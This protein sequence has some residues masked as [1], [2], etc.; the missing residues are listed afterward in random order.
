MKFY[1]FTPTKREGGAQKVLTILKG[2]GR[3]HKTLWGS[4]HAGA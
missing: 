4:F 2:G 3:E 1:P